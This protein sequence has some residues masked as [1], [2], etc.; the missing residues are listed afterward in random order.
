MACANVQTNPQFNFQPLSKSFAVFPNDFRM[1]CI[2]DILPD[3]RVNTFV[4]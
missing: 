4:P 3:L 2:L 1:D